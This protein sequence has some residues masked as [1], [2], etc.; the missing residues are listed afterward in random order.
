MSSNRNHEHRLF[1]DEAQEAMRREI[2]AA[3]G[4]EV[5]FFGW[6]HE[7]GALDRI[8]VI[9]RGNDVSVAVPLDRSFLPD[10]VIHNHPDGILT[11]SDQDVHMSSL[12]ANRGVGFYIVNNQATEVYVVIE[13][14]PRRKTVLLDVEKL[15]KI[16]SSG[17]P[18]NTLF[19]HFEERHGQMKMVEHV[20][21]AFNNDEHVLIEAGTGIGKSLAY[22]IP[23]AGWALNNN[24]KVVISTNTINLQEQLLYKDIPDLKRASGLDFKYTLMKGRGNYICLN[25]LNEAKQDLFALIDDDE[26]EQFNA[27]EGWLETTD[28][29]SLSNLPFMPKPSLWEKINSQPGTCL[30]GAC[31]FFSECYVNRARRHA[32]E[33]HIIV[34]NH[35]YVLAD[36]QSN[37]SGAA[38]LPPYQRV[39]FDEAHNLESSATSFFTKNVTL[40]AVL[41]I[42]N[43]LYTG[44]RKKKGY[45]VYLMNRDIRGLESRVIPI[46]D[47][48]RQARSAAFELFSGIDEFIAAL[49]AANEDNPVSLFEVTDELR[50]HA[51]W[52]ACVL[53]RIDA[54]YKSCSRLVNGLLDIR[55]HLAKGGNERYVR[56]VEGLT[57]RLIETTE[58][59]DKFL[60]ENDETW[61]RWIQKKRE[62]GIVVA[63]VEV[64]DVLNEL[65]FSRM[66]SLV[67]T[68]ATLTV[69]DRFDFIKSRLHIGDSAQSVILESSFDYDRQMV[70]LI[71]QNGPG[72]NQ[73]RYI[74]SLACSITSVL[75]KTHGKAFVLFTS[76]TILNR[77]FDL[78]KNAL[79]AEGFVLFRQG[80]ETRS[81]LMERFRGD[82]HSVLFGTESFWEGVDAPGE[83]LE[84]VIIT[85]LPFKVPTEPIIRAR[86]EKIKQRGGNPFLEYYVPLAVIKMKQGIG[87][88][89]RNRSDRGIIVILDNRLLVKS[90]GS[91]FLHSI[92]TVNIHRGALKAMLEDAESFLSIT[93]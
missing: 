42:L 10:V 47:F 14:V 60:G 13:P 93:P 76:Y 66:K 84:C 34:T 40:A 37:S 23:S 41:R 71:P 67:L 39:I 2:E 51:M 46:M 52:D 27:I 7:N 20:S 31:A 24:E 80:D 88:L 70:V 62:A 58:A 45:L 78:V 32:A 5:L 90:Y 21:G 33:A 50:N 16:I 81:R 49:N 35:H 19:P 56:Q 91:L 30:G 89:I 82:I 72:P 12:I 4:N 74:E 64:G 17:G 44:A 63:L 92:P 1:S 38:L 43:S 11:P 85:K 83:T 9:A 6:I 25:R 65:L 55:A 75:R 57:G 73:P 86:I 26:V 15:K 59:I 79:S 3:G 77:V 29:V 8:E 53:K 48:V 18:F 22:L 87:R 28:D 69:D 61:V 68:S 36:A 54:F